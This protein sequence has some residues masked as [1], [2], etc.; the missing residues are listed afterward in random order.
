MSLNTMRMMIVFGKE[1][2]ITRK[3]LNSVAKVVQNNPE[4]GNC[5]IAGSQIIHIQRQANIVICGTGN[6]RILKCMVHADLNSETIALGE[7]SSWRLNTS[8]SI[9]GELTADYML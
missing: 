1:E 3:V 4:C 5:D 2:P 7:I 8:S 9:L 6:P